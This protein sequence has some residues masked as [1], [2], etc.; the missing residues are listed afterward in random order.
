[1]RGGPDF[2]NM[3][4]FLTETALYRYATPHCYDAKEIPETFGERADNLPARTPSTNYT[5][6]WLGGCWR[7][8]RP[9]TTC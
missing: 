1:M 4:G 9:W 3:L 8:A 2:H 5:N 6:P 7:C